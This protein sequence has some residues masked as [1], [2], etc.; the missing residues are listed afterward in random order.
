MHAGTFIKSDELTV[1]EYLELCRDA[2]SD[3][4]LA[5]ILAETIHENEKGAKRTVLTT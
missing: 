5:G 3:Q 1:S 2:F 4:D